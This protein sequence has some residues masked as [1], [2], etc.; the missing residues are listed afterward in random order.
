MAAVDRSR[1]SM[2]TMSTIWVLRART[3]DSVT[4]GRPQ[5]TRVTGVAGG[6]REARPG[7]SGGVHKEDG[8]VGWVEGTGA[9]A[10]PKARRL[11]GERRAAKAAT[12]KEPFSNQIKTRATSRSSSQSPCFARKRPLSSSF[13]VRGFT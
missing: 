2:R 5:E 8:Y 1:S 4:C 3:L 13:M 12:S 11:G 6:W 9:G 10:G 7:V